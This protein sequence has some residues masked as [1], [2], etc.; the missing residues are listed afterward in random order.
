MAVAHC[1]TAALRTPDFHI[2]CA[3]TGD[4][5]ANIEKRNGLIENKTFGESRDLI[6]LRDFLRGLTEISPNP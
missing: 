6:N 4:F 3:C 2:V 1:V 5:T